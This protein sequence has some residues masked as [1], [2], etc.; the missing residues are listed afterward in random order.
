MISRRRGRKPPQGRTASALPQRLPREIVVLIGAGFVIAL[1]YGLVA[2][3]LPT[4]ARSFDVG[5]TAA[6]AV[7]SA[8][9]VFRLAFA[10]VS[11][12]LV[13]RLGELRVYSA[14][15]RHRRRVH[16]GVRVRR[17]VLAVAGVPRRWAVSARRCSRSRRCRCSSASRRRTCGARAS[18]LWATGF[19][20]GNIT[21]PVRRRWPGHVRAARAVRGLRGAAPG[22]RHDP[23]RPAAAGPGRRG[24]VDGPAVPE[25]SRYA[26]HSGTR[27]TAR[28]SRPTFAN[29]WAVF[30]VR[31]ALV[32]LF[33][34]EALHRSS[35]WAGVALTASAMG[36]G[37]CLQLGGRWSDR[38]GR[39]A[40]VLVGSA[41]VAVT[42]LALGFCTSVAALIVVSPGRRR[43]RADD[44][45]GE[46]GGRRCHR[47]AGPR[48][49]WWYRCR[50]VPDG[51]RRRG[52]GGAGGGGSSSNGP[53]TPQR[54]ATTAVIAVMALVWW[55]RAP[56]TR[57]RSRSGH[58]VLA[59]RSRVRNRVVGRE[60]VHRRVG[61]TS[62]SG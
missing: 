48:R 54:F 12:R 40:P 11:G 18:G 41:V 53:C 7:I 35:A 39:R 51:R 55:W 56:D 36:T 34:V 28:R 16:R 44:P 62:G 32:P 25:I 1:G 29:G 59:I 9:A 2:P 10:P 19:L 58:E 45:V 23:D 47:R 21:G 60:G 14:R 50:R 43:H 52:G 3:A 37:A 31:V 5:V 42:G 38:S 6:S 33:V 15:P 46:R 13:A 26:P 61:V 57:P 4:F 27:R 24:P 49:S 30:G 20:L 8:F 17:G 22:R